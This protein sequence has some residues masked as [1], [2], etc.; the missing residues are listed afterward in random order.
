MQ[1]QLLEMCE[2]YNVKQLMIVMKQLNKLNFSLSNLRQQGLT[3]F[4]G[5]NTD[6]PFSKTKQFPDDLYVCTGAGDWAR[7][8][9]QLVTALSYKSRD[10]DQKT[11]RDDQSHADY[12]DSQQS[13]YNICTQIVQQIVGRQYVF[14]RT[15]FESYYGLKW[16]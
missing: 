15:F 8:F 4:S 3:T 16:Q 6:C 7:K 2:W 10:K 12:N 14:D 13:Y 5:L 1:V 11:A 9:Q